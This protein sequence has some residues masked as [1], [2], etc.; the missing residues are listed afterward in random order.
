M[1]LDPVR[2]E[3]GISE[4]KCSGY[5]NMLFQHLSSVRNS[6]GRLDVPPEFVS[7]QTWPVGPDPGFPIRGEEPDPQGDGNPTLG[8]NVRQNERIG[9][10]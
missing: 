10:Y 6:K 2:G 7:R 4:N 8:K 1:S 9:S 5:P 3:E